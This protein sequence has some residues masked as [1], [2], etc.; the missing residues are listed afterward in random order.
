VADVA[1]ERLESPRARLF[2]ALDL[3]DGMREEIDA[4]GE[5]ELVDP[6]LRKA[7]AAS[8]HVTLVF[9]GYR[10][11]KEIEA[12]KEVVGSLDRPTPR[13]RLLDPVPRPERGRPRL[14][15]LPLD[16]PELVELQGELQARLA[17][18]GL[19]EPEKRP[20]WPHVTVARVRPDKRG[21]RKPRTVERAPGELPQDLVRTARGVRISLYLSKLKPQ[22]AEYV[23][24]AHVKLR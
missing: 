16:S 1:K 15:A 18:A 2:V 24:L 23:P 9:I 3:P 5:R 11:E 13:L 14:Y 7:S 8:I 10:P 4:W 19:H 20:F 6:A 22:G 12:F 21:S 17:A